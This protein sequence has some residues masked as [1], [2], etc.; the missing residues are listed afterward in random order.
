MSTVLT[1]RRT[2]GRGR[3][4][5]STRQPSLFGQ[6]VAPPAPR[7]P[8]EEEAVEAAVFDVPTTER[9]EEQPGTQ[10][11]VLTKPTLDEAMSGL[12]SGLLSGAVGDC[13][14]C[15][16]A[17]EPR[18]SAGNGVVGGRCGGCSVTLG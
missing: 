14:V 12:W 15:G 10:S 8:R 4:R 6:V 7:E 13:P 11:A 1:R 18:H 2:K 3:D 17:M 16:S 9:D 5:E